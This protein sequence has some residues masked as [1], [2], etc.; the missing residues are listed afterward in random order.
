MTPNGR[1]PQK[2]KSEISQQPLVD[3][4]QILNSS[5]VNHFEVHR[6]LEWRQPKQMI[7]EYLSNHWIK[8][9]NYGDQADMYRGL[10]WRQP[11]M[12]LKY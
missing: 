12:D 4:S 8:L 2:I 9:L 7:V 5:W 6:G 1:Q 10:K 3:L 11:Q